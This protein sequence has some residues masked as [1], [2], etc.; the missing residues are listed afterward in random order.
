[1]SVERCVERPCVRLESEVR[2]LRAQVAEV[3]DPRGRWGETTAVATGGRQGATQ[4][5]MLLQ[6]FRN[7]HQKGDPMG[8]LS[9]ALEV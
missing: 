5:Q 7:S 6:M 2:R 8:R 3:E 4:L 1:M 9:N